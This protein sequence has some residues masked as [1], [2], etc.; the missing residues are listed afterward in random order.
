MINNYRY[1]LVLA[2]ELNIS[3]SAKRL[4][5][6]HQALSAYLKN[7][8]NECGV[9]LFHRKPNLAL[10]SAGKLVL[11]S[12]KKIDQ[13]EMNLSS[14]IAELNSE[15]GAG[16]RL[17]LTEGRYRILA[18]ILLKE[19]NLLYKNTQLDIIYG[20]SVSLENKILNNEIDIYLTSSRNVKS[21]K[22][23]I[24]PIIEESIYLVISDNLLMEYFPNTWKE[25]KEKKYEG[26]ELS[27]FKFVPFITNKKGYNSR[28]VLDELLEKKNININIIMES[29]NQDI[30]Y[31]ISNQNIAASFCWS[32][33][34]NS[35]KE[36]NK[37]NDGKSEL[38]LF[39]VHD[40]D[41]SNILSIIH[42]NDAFISKPKCDLINLLKSVCADLSS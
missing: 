5:L 21:N 28:R 10:T 33:Y 22:L 9:R 41:E 39:P 36:I 30:L 6:S 42:L 27:D 25:Y 35:I 15:G 34:R 37:L 12:L 3:K 1:F 14:R 13:I 31:L 38:N 18:P 40:L 19:F 2:Q 24:N 20:D 23:K 11:D 29:T 26:V 7:L 16:I 4:R 8:E 17:G 32:M